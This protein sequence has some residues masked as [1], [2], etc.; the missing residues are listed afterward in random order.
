MGGWIVK[1]NLDVPSQGDVVR[2]PALLMKRD[3]FLAFGFWLL[4]L[5]LGFYSRLLPSPAGTLPFD[6]F[7]CGKSG[8]YKALYIMPGE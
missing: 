2:K 3:I 6:A 7:Y 8:T 1:V 5:L 4:F